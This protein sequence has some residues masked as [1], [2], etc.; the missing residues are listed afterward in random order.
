MTEEELG[1]VDRV[2]VLELLERVVYPRTEIDSWSLEENRLTLSITGR[3][4]QEINET[5]QLLLDEE[6]VSYCEVNTASTEAKN[7]KSETLPDTVTAN[8]MV[9]LSKPEGGT[10]K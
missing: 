2:A 10:E 9:Y 5:V 6:L 1:R 7:T 4:L 8:V 3:T